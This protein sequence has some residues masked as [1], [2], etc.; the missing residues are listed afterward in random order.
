MSDHEKFSLAVMVR[1][2]ALG[3]LILAPAVQGEPVD[4]PMR[5]PVRE[6]RATGSADP[7]P[8]WSLTSVLIADDR[9][10]AIINDRVLREGESVAGARVVRIEADHVLIRHSDG[11]RRLSLRTGLDISRS[12]EQ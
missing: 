3:L 10:L 1:G 12:S 7:H 8:G 5:P 9:R 11:E 2:L 6:S 4:D